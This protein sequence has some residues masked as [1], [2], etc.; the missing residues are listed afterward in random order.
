L[1]SGKYQNPEITGIRNPD[2]TDLA[3]ENPASDPVE[4]KRIQ[5]TP[6]GSQ[7]NFMRSSVTANNP[8]AYDNEDQ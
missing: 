6:I 5:H 2:L 7:C 8:G 4:N 3:S 1:V